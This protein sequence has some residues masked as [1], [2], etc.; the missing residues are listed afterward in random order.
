MRR[1]HNWSKFSPAM[2]LLYVSVLLICCGAVPEQAGAAC[3]A[4]QDYQHWI[5]TAEIEGVVQDICVQGHYA[6]VTDDGPVFE[7][8]TILDITN[9]SKPILVLMAVQKCGG[10]RS[11]SAALWLPRGR[12]RRSV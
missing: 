2:V 1:D 6:Y 5:S 7:G 11:K 3:T 4:Y 8:L 12:W 10:W 9:K